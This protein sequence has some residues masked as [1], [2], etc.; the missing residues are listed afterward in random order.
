[1]AEVKRYS[2]KFSG[3][4]PVLFET[5]DGTW[6][7]DDDYAR[8]LDRVAELERERDSAQAELARLRAVEKA[9]KNAILHS[10]IGRDPDGEKYLMVS[11]DDMRALAEACGRKP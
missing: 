10:V 3:G 8:L 4:H 2:L 5:D 11:L 7:S 1:M 6:R 9:A